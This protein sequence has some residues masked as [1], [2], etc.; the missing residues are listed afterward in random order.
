MM[1]IFMADEA[2]HLTADVAA[3]RFVE[4]LDKSDTGISFEMDRPFRKAL[5]RLEIAR[6]RLPPDTVVDSDA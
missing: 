6:G 5:V 2:G 3:A 4:L 1:E